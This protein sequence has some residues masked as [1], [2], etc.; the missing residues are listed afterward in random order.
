L[1]PNRDEADW[2][3]AEVNALRNDTQAVAGLAAGDQV[4]R[5]YKRYSLRQWIA[6]LAGPRFDHL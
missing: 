4:A 3:L 6:G 5:G 2:A 1:A